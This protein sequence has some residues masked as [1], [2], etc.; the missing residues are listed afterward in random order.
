MHSFIT[1]EGY[2]VQE[3]Y[4]EVQRELESRLDK[5]ATFASVLLSAI[6]FSS[7][8]DMMS[9]VRAGRGVVF[10][11]PLMSLDE[12]FYG[13]QE[14]EGPGESR[15]KEDDEPA[16]EKCSWSREGKDSSEKMESEFNFRK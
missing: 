4:T 1:K 12:E 15:W 10:C 13:D 14:Q 7:F 2:S 5:D 11:P 16:E 8:C 9:D 3:F 6:D